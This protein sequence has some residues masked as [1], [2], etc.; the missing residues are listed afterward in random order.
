[1]H[2]IPNFPYPSLHAP[3]QTPKAPQQSGQQAAMKASPGKT[4][5]RQS[6]KRPD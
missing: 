6:A 3:E 1:M 4:E 5:E 2:E